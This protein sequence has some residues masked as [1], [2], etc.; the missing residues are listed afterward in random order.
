MKKITLDKLCEQVAAYVEE[1]HRAVCPPGTPLR[2]VMRI[3]AIREICDEIWWHSV[4]RALALASP[5]DG[6]AT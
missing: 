1:H 3:R 2:P 6:R 5:P 4:D